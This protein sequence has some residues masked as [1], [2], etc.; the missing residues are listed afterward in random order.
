MGLLLCLLAVEAGAGILNSPYFV[1][2]EIRMA[3]SAALL[4]G[5]A[6]YPGRDA[7]SP[8][9]GTL[10]TP[11]SHCLYLVAAGFHNPTD[12]LLAGSLLSLLLVFVPLGWVLW[13][14]SEGASDR[15]LAAAAVFLFC[16]FLVMQAPG[17]FHIASMIHGDAAAVA[18]A[19]VACGVFSNRLKPITA[20]QVWMAGLAAVLAVGS[21]QTIAPIVLAIALF[22]AVASGARLVAHFV[23]A[24][25]VG[26]AVLMGVIL[27][28]VPLRAFLFNTVTLAAHL[29]L[30]VGY[31]GLLVRAF[32]EGK[33]DS[34]PAVFPIML[35]A[36]GQWIAAK[37]RP[38]LRDFFRANR[39]AVFAIAATAQIP[40]VVKAVA[41]SGADV[42]HPG[43]ALYLLFVAASL[44][45]EQHVTDPDQA[46]WRGLA[47]MCAAVGILVGIAPG[48]LLSLPSRV[49]DLRVSP[50]EM[51]LRYELRHPGHAY[52]P[53]NPLASLQSAGKAY[54]VDYSVYDREIAGYPLTPQQFEAGLPPGFEV[55]AVPPGEQ[56]RSSALRRMLER[57][58]PTADIE[59]PG[60]TVYKRW[61]PPAGR[62]A[63]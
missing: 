38:G 50:P 49:R 32:R 54:H 27:E 40:V 63:E 59:L 16:G 6:I 22:L 34:L 4:H 2:N 20:A 41:T 13:R 58:R 9:V 60:W 12:A 35:L 5:F 33:Q 14:A 1:W 25:F 11:V 15:L 36:G 7:S 45:I 10:H 44:A 43:A 56:P 42:N 3:R 24:V 19:T 30:K 61:D 51:A 26:G 39:W 62:N 47:W 37:R 57:Y 53:W 8:I 46:L 31:I 52:F 18:F 48:T 55:V 21:K 29:P 17:T 28:F 23:A